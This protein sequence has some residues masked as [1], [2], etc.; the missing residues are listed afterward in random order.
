MA[1]LTRIGALTENTKSVTGIAIMLGGG[2]I[3]YKSKFQV[4]VALSSMEAE[5]VAACDTGKQ[6]L[7]LQSILTELGYPQ[8]LSTVLY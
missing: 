8:D 4:T 1:L 6:I 5:F 2:V 3:C 7:Y